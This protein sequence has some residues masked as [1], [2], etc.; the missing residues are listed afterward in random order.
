MFHLSPTPAWLVGVFLTG[1]FLVH[2]TLDELYSVD[3]LGAR[4]KRSF[5]TALKLGS[6]RQLLGTTALYAGVITLVALGPPSDRF[7]RD[8]T[9]KRTWA[10]VA[11]TFDGLR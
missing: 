10:A 8:V 7:L 5:G 6:M 11:A 9:S 2:L 4:M 3:L 1:G